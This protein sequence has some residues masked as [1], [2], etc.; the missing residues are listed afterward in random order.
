MTVDRNAVAEIAPKGVSNAVLDVIEPYFPAL[1]RLGTDAVTRFLD[2][3]LQQDWARVD[4]ELYADMTEDERDA[5]SASV[6]VDAR[7]AV[8]AAY[9]SSRQW[10]GDLTKTLL[11]VVLSLV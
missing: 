9:E 2:G 8:K 1:K 4:R 10:S 7:Q 11:S 5:L 3:A 6:L